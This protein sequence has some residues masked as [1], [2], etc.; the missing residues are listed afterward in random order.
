MQSQ[1]TTLKNG[2]RI[3]TADFPQLES[4]SVGIW[5]NT[6]SAYE[7]EDNNG[8]SHFLEHM[9]FKGTKTRSA[10]Q[11][12]EEIEDAGGQSNAY[13]AREFTAYYAKMLKNDIE[14]AVDVL[15]DSLKN[16]TFPE[17]ELQKEREVVVQEIK[18]T[19]DAPDDIIFDYF[20][21]TAFP[22]QALGRSILG[23]KEKVR[24]FNRDTLQNYLNSNY[25]AKNM[26]ACAVG[27]VN[28]QAFV[29]MI[30]DRLGD[31]KTDT[32]FVSDEQIYKGGF[33]TETRPIEQAHIAL[34]FK[35]LP[36]QTEDYY[37]TMLMASM[38]GGGMSSR[39]FQEV[40]EK[41]GLAYSVYSFAAS[42]TKSGMFGIYAGTGANDLKDLVPVIT[43]ELNKIC[44]D[45]FTDKELLRAQTQMK[46]S[47]LMVLENPSSTAEM[48]A[49]QMLIYNRIIPVEEMVA[50]IEKV[51]LDDIQRLAQ[52]IFSSKPTYAL[53]GAVDKRIEYDELQKLMEN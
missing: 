2:L 17:E 23:T 3:I 45:K 19:I 1:I 18:Q 50:R 10:C 5:V 9:S 8:I 15:T 25:G 38:L 11:L 29:K 32:N 42:H 4:V 26:V 37:P 7:K 34:G 24:S 47:M 36:Y 21:E 35:G 43:E 28:H 46:A 39:L 31:Y 53:L 44:N 48:L 41:R 13:T 20:Q 22:N 52:N 49:R 40:R 12:S 51:T 33:F 30:E 27:N 14:L 6:G 16:S